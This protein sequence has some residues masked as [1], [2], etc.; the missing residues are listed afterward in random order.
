[1]SPWPGSRS[2]RSAPR[3][4]W[5]PAST[6]RRWRPSSASGWPA[7]GGQRSWSVIVSSLIARIM[8]LLALIAGA[9]A[10]LFGWRARRAQARADH[11][12]RPAQA[13]GAAPGA[14]MRARRAQARA[15]RAVR[16]AESAAAVPEPRLPAEG[17]HLEI[18]ERRAVSH[19]ETATE[20]GDEL[21]G[22]W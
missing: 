4:R 20:R 3:P 7:S 12:Q 17:P 6:A 15:D 11:A 2:A 21:A 14:P 18:R 16:R 10:A 19:R 13:A 22:G 5:V 8:S 9:V 1:H